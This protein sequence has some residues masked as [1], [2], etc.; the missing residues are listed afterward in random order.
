VVEA[1]FLR[2]EQLARVLA[3]IAVALANGLCAELR[4]RAILN[5]NFRMAGYNPKR[6]MR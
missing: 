6:T 4:G 1:A 5:R 2:L 3:A